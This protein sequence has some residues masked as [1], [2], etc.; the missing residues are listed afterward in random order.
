MPW[1]ETDIGHFV[2]S[3]SVLSQTGKKKAGFL[4]R[5]PLILS[6]FSPKGSANWE[7]ANQIS[8]D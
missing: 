4:E 7:L 6:L 2:N 5:N 8:P 1:V 3:D